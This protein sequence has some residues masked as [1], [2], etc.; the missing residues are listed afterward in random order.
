VFIPVE[1][2]TG[3]YIYLG[4][5]NNNGIADEEEFAPVVFDGDFILITI[6]TDELFP[7]IELRASTRWKIIYADI[8]DRKSVLGSILKP[9]STE[10]VWRIEEITREEDFSKI[11]LLNFNH[12]QVEGTTIR[13]TNFF[14]QDIFINENSSELSF[15]FRFLQNKKMSEFNA[16]VERG[17]N[18]ERSL[19][20]RFRMVR[21][22]SNQTDIVNKTNNNSSANNP[23]R[24]LAITENNITTD[25]SYRPSRNLEV[26]FVLK[27]G[28][29]EDTFPEIPTVVDLNTQRLRFN[30]SFTGLGRLRIEIER[31]ELIANTEENFIP[32][33]LTGS[34]QLGKNYFARVNFDYRVAS[35]LQITVNYEGRLQEAQRVIHTA[36]AEARAYF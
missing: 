33:E 21:E 2:G 7:V 26:G 17:Y 10:T 5:L 1:S 16:G 24:N 13:G 27:V 32:F 29:S 22:F 9:L 3:N 34:N 28:K 18:R 20:I 36:R 11:Y 35:F 25:F 6:P 12:F 23:T 30:L 15:R 19:R 8:F 4:D 31:S 14:Q